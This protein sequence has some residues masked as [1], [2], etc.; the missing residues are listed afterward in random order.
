MT[1]ARGR[2]RRALLSRNVALATKAAR[3]AAPLPL[4]DALDF[5]LLLAEKA[6]DRYQRAAGRLAARLALERNLTLVEQG[7]VMRL[8]DRLPVDPEGTRLALIPICRRGRA[9]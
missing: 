1:E 4:D 6:D 8:L 2:F 5:V 3:A 7:E 9:A